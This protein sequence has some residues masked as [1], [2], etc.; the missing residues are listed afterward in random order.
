MEIRQVIEMIDKFYEL[1]TQFLTD[2][3]EVREETIQRLLTLREWLEKQ[4]DVLRHDKLV[5]KLHVETNQMLARVN[6]PSDGSNP[7]PE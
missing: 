2:Y 6:L 3:P 4:G 5:E 1:K 7:Q